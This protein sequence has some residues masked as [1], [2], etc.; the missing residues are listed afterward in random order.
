MKSI[1]TAL[2]IIMGLS[3]F[4]LQSPSGKAAGASLTFSPNQG[5]F[6][7][8]N[9][10]DVSLVINTGGSAVNAIEATIK[11]PPDK[12]QVVQL[13]KSIIEIWVAQPSF[14][15]TEGTINLQGG[16]PNPGLN[17][18][19]GT[20]ISITFRAKGTGVA[21][22]SIAQAKVLANDGNGTNILSSS[23]QGNY[24]LSLAPPAGPVI[25][26]SSHPDQE[27]W[28][29]SNDITFIWTA[30]ENASG[31]SYVFDNNPNT[32]PD[33]ETEITETS[34]NLK[35]PHDGLWYFSLRAKGSLWGG[36]SHFV[37]RID[38]TVPAEFEPQIS[39]KFLTEANRAIA[40]F[41]TTDSPSGLDHYEVKII[42]SDASGSSVTAFTEATSPYLLPELSSGQYKL[43][44]RAVD[45]AGNYREVEKSFIVAGA[46][47]AIFTNQFLVGAIALL[48]TVMLT[49]LL[50]WLR[51]RHQ[52][53]LFG[54]LRSDLKDIKTLMQQK[55]Q[56]LRQLLRLE[57][58]SE[59]TLEQLE[60][61][62]DDQ[63]PL[64][65][66]SNGR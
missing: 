49:L 15:N 3:L 45:R 43:I 14:S 59:A 42:S 46:G 17:T 38:T 2:A 48:A 29:N 36:T 1:V 39:P 61:S 51:R 25:S 6:F 34:I 50:L 56:E 10:F 66:D 19:A 54:R 62:A 63:P 47:F 44:V 40:T 55:R 20:V 37:T 31:Y 28:Y 27:R 8:E 7:A 41:Q 23:G 5:E 16:I 11:F 30:P 53:A 64:E 24:S 60:E 18:S 26:S 65:Q 4:P 58:E 12:L 21:N 35:A 33:G 9:T 32:I 52:A 57:Q 13:L 22:L